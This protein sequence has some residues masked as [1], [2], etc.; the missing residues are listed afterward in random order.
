M[1][2]SAFRE[3]AVGP[4]DFHGVLLAAA[5]AAAGLEGKAVVASPG[6]DGGDVL[7]CP[8]GA[9]DELAAFRCD[10]AARD[11]EGEV[12]AAGVAPIS[13]VLAVIVV[14]KTTTAGVAGR[15]VLGVICDGA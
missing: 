4:D 14:E 15:R 13:G 10:A 9:V 3:R 6:V 2:S 5:R 8:A 11:V 1:L 7:Q 12:G